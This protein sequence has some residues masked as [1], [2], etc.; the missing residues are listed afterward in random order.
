MPSPWQ[1]DYATLTTSVGLVDLIGRTQVELTGAD[2]AKFLHN[3]CTNEIKKLAALSGAEAMLLNAK[4]HILFHVVAFNRGESIVL[5]SV[6]GVNERLAQHLDRYLIREQVEIVDRTH[7]WCVLLIA[8]PQAAETLQKCGLNDV[9]E[10]PLSVSEATLAGQPVQIRRVSLASVPAWELVTLND[11]AETVRQA[12]LAAGAKG[13]DPAALEPLRIEAGWPQAE[14]DIS[15]KNLP[16]ELNRDSTAISF[17]KGCYIGQETVA[18]IDA[19]GHVNKY[20]ARL[21]FAVGATPNVGDE[22]THDGKSVGSVTSVAFSPRTETVVGLG[23][24]RHGLHTPGTKLDSA[25]GSVE[26]WDGR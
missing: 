9:P 11:H 23:Y 20:L 15:D 21:R 6:T 2:R 19:L 4:G 12:L 13:C 16:Q 5:D 18:R 1:A 26:V 8:G 24:V 25:H 17:V 10:S 22:L 3:L 14:V 7:E